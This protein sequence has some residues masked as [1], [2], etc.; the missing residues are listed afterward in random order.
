MRSQYLFSLA[1]VAFATT[2]LAAPI[3]TTLVERE[4]FPEDIK[5]AKIAPGK[6]FEELSERDADDYSTLAVAEAS[7][8]QT[9][10]SKKRDAKDPATATRSVI[11]PMRPVGPLSL[12]LLRPTIA[13]SP[14]ESILYCGGML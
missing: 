5:A 8:S 11:H 14:P 9:H 12:L 10:N 13:A 7:H 2:S 4:P 3:T 6:D 1:L